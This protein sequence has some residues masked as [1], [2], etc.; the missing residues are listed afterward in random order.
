M[1]TRSA[2]RCFITIFT[3]CIPQELSP[4]INPLETT[5]KVIYSFTHLGRFLQN[6]SFSPEKYR[7]CFKAAGL[8]GCQRCAFAVG[9]DAHEARNVRWPKTGVQHFKSRFGKIQEEREKVEKR[10]LTGERGLSQKLLKRVFAWTHRCILITPQPPR[11]KEVSGSLFPSAHPSVSEQWYRAHTCPQCTKKTHQF[12][13]QCVAEILW[14]WWFQHLFLN[15]LWFISGHILLLE[16]DWCAPS[17][18]TA[19]N[20]NHQTI[21]KQ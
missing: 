4:A 8:N 5:Q 1:Q 17:D 3:Y 21:I 14:C 20:K 6:C 12:I 19:N 15:C 16:H 9:Q 18:E 10:Q 11:K 7:R 13:N 2:F